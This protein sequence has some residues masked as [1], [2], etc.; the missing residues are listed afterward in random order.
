MRKI[1]KEELSEILKQHNIWL[2]SSH[3]LGSRANLPEANISRTE[4]YGANLSKANLSGADLSYTKLVKANLSRANL[5][6]ANL[7]K[8]DLSGADLSKAD[9]SKAD[10]SG[11]NLSGADLSRANLYGANLSGANLSG[12]N[13]YKADLYGAKGIAVFRYEKHLALAFDNNKYIAIGCKQY[14]TRNWVK[15][16]EKIGNDENYSVTQIKMYGQFINMINEN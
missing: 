4:L 13:L 3:K 8:A 7:S 16:F 14:R 5:S 11:A 15:N 2:Y 9:L 10:L 1:S 12:A 6:E